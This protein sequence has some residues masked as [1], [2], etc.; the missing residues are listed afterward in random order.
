MPKTVH[1]IFNA[2][3]DP[4][5]L[6]PW[7]AGVDEALATC[8]TACDRL[9]AHPELTFSRGEAWI[10]KIVEELDPPLFARIRRFVDE[11]RWEIVGGWWIQPDCNFPSGFAMEKQVELGKA[12]FESRFG[13]MPEVAY[14]VD[15]FG[16]A[17][18]LPGLMARHGQR[19]YCFM[20]P[21]PHE[22]ELPARLF[23]WRG[24]PGGPEV[25]C[26][27]IANA[28]TARR[29]DLDFVQATLR[30]LPEGIDHTMC[31]LGIGDHG[32]GPTE[33]LIAWC[34]EHRHA[35]PDTE[36]VYSTPGRYFKAIESQIP[37]LPL[38]EGELQMHAV[39]CYTVH[40]GVKAG[41][42]RAEHMLA[43]VESAFPETHG[44]GEA[45]GR[46][47]FHH[48][49]DTLGGT[50]LPSA[51]PAIED[52]LAF[53][54]SLAQHAIVRGMRKRMLDLPDD[55]LQRMVFLNA[56]DQP[57]DG[58]VESEPWLDLPELPFE[59]WQPE[60]HLLDDAGGDVP[61]QI[62]Q[63]EA[64]AWSNA[65]FLVPLRLEANELRAL[66]VARDGGQPSPVRASGDSERLLADGGVTIE[67]GAWR[68]PSG[69]V[70]DIPE[71]VSIEDPTDTW[72]HRIV[73]YDGPVADRATWTPPN[74]IDQGPLMASWIQTGA[75]GASRLHAEWRVFADRPC[76]ELRL[77]VHWLERHRVLKLVWPLA[78]PRS[79]RIDG[80][81]GGSTR[82]PNNGYEFPMRD[83]TIAGQGVVS[84]DVFAIDANEEAMRLTLLRSP[85]LAHHDPYQ[86]N[87]PRGR[88]ADQG[89]HEFR[90]LFFDQLTPKDAETHT[91]AMHRP[92]WFA[93]LTRGMPVTHPE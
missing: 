11:G 28:Y 49:H 18:Y 38:V 62:V 93:D 36:L 92:L 46:V 52:D 45:W 7:S 8:R 85:W 73:G 64:Q 63:C 40:R 56:S 86:G 57:F 77:R 59:S 91:Y 26:F 65:R 39:G 69:T 25:V 82:R 76:V 12:Y 10:Y 75:I 53:A 81:I 79:E 42:R 35:L 58:F 88:Y 3:I 70:L 47:C 1:L 16:H 22:M 61:F 37:S 80:T 6:W 48:F 72:S 33:E 20:R 4:V 44:L 54:R 78:E 34:E 43:Q 29:I 21:G 50:C 67:C 9:D 87:A 89:E 31:F 55:R 90:F 2:H 15:S 19:F 30:D 83:W 23:R 14:N 68:F 71:L 32:G 60:F 24:E 84:P 27:R 66:K 74:A 5:W 41:L 51:Y 13:Q 17:T